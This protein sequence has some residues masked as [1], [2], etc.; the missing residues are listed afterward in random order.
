M[1]SKRRGQDTIV[2]DGQHKVISTLIEKN[3]I[4]L[5]NII[6]TKGS[7]TSLVRVAYA[8]LKEAVVKIDPTLVEKVNKEHEQ[9][10]AKRKI[11]IELKNGTLGTSK[12]HFGKV[13]PK[14]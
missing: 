6:H 12:S 2:V 14:F 5:W 10:K 7:K 11:A 8:K 4:E 1:S 9:Y 3:P 13:N